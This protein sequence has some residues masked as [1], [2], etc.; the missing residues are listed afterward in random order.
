MSPFTKEN[1]L[2]W[3]LRVS[4]FGS[5]PFRHP[6][7]IWVYLHGLLYTFSFAYMRLLEANHI[8]LSHRDVRFILLQMTGRVIYDDSVSPVWS[9]S[10]LRMPCIYNSAIIHL[11]ILLQGTFRLFPSFCCYSQR[12]TEHSGTRLLEI[13]SP[14]QALSHTV[15]FSSFFTRFRPREASIPQ[16]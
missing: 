1:V 4:V 16:S 3:L 15:T 9:F 13:P 14:G 12:L 11:S 6:R 8:V 2:L 10:L 5:I 7:S